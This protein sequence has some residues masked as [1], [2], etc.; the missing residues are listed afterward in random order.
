MVM[1]YWGIEV[2]EP[3]LHECCQSTVSGTR[4]ED[5]VDCARQYGF[6]AEHRR[7]NEMDALAQWLEKGVFPIVLLNMFPIDALWRMH[8]VVVIGAGEDS[9]HFLDPVGGE[10]VTSHLAFEQA[11]R[12][13]LGR[14]VIIAPAKPGAAEAGDG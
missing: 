14:A 12:M 8:A 5:A 7:N 10:R 13:N 3:S 9:V 6:S 2:D 11:W 4:A 1:A